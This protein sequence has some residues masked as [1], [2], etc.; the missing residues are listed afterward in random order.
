M[1][2]TYLSHSCFAL[3]GAS[4]RLIIDPFLTGN[5]LAPIRPEEVAADYILVTHGHGDHLGDTVAI[6][7][8]TGATVISTFEVASVC[9]KRGAKAHAMNHG[10]AWSFPFGRVK[11]TLAH[12]SSS[13]ETETGFGYLGNPA[14]L[15]ITMEGKTFYHAGDTA[16]FLDMKL[17]GELD[18]IDVAM[19]PIGDNFTMG[20]EDA[21]RAV[22]FLGAKLALPMHYN[23][24]PQIEVDPQR[25]LDACKGRGRVLAIGET[26][27]V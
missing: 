11:V 6:A 26:I 13:E 14:G 21:G 10:G 7:R 19:L 24:F 12:H 5:P 4:H 8:R 3:E 25:F 15:L 27:E 2:L 17:I 23:T 16:L 9:G 1:K 18:P 22:D 20:P